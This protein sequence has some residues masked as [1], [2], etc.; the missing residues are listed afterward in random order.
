MVNTL[1]IAKSLGKLSLHWLDKN[2]SYRK[3]TVRRLVQQSGYSKTMAGAML[4]ALFKELRYPKLM[5][6][7]KSE[8][9]DPRVLDEFRKD[10]VG[11]HWVRARGPGRILHILSGNVPQPAIMSFILGMLVK[12]R[13][14]GKVSSRDP[15][16]LDIYLESLKKTDPRLAAANS[17][18]RPGDKRALERA[19][20]E[21]DLVVAYGDD[22]TL[23]WIRVRLPPQ[24]EY[25]GYRHRVSYG[26]FMKGSLRS[27]GAVSLARK[28][29][30]DVW[31]VNRRGCLSPLLFYVQ[32]GGEV[33]PEHFAGMVVRKLGVVNQE[34]GVK[35]FRDIGKVF[36]ALASHS[37]HLQCV[38]LEA[39]HR[40]RLKLAAR[41]GGL[42]F[43]RICRA[44]QMQNP[45]LTW[46]H[47][48]KF[49]LASWVTWTDL[50]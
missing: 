35:P 2:F 33:S 17:L 3:K 38:A 50:E 18:I 22:R 25:F 36:S 34:A 14:I 8:L 41:L 47:D 9:R 20:Q 13:N 42:G 16:F 31:M 7:L 10:P 4:D 28:A 30:R 23:E 48:G 32:R 5:K 12:S 26:L 1:S 24:A 43:N 15:G 11:G 37:R 21:A 46:H 6:L 44:G 19:I 45:P 39:P 27:K 49:N 29:A 40:E